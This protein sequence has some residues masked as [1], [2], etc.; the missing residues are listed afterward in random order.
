M[1]AG[2]DFVVAAL[3]LH[4]ILVGVSSNDKLPYILHHF[5][6]KCTQTTLTYQL[7]DPDTSSSS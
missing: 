3:T 7:Y 4:D 2:L 5:K 1:L 6:M